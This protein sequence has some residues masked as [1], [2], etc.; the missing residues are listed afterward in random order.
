MPLG[1]PGEKNKTGNEIIN[2]VWRYTGGNHLDITE[3]KRHKWGYQEE[4]Q[5][6]EGHGL[7]SGCLKHF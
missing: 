6:T 1:D 5:M 2:P 3:I 4:Y 7:N